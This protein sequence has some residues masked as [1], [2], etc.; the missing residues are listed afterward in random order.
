MTQ[1]AYFEMCEALGTEPLEEEIPVEIQDF[2][3][4]IQNS[5]AMYNV[6]SDIWDTMGGNYLGKDYSI[7]FN[8]FELY[9]IDDQQEKLLHLNI[10]QHIDSVRAAMTREKIKA[11]QAEKPAK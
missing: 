5:F 11:A 9:D 8:L 7:L 3:D 4:T 2:P 6:L 10:M 1:E